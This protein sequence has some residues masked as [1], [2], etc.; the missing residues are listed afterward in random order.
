MKIEDRYLNG[1]YHELNPDWDRGD[2][3]WK[4]GHVSEMILKHDVLP[5][6]ICEI[7]CGSGD[8]LRNLMLN[9]PNAKM[10]GFDVSPALTN[11]WHED[12][13]CENKIKFILGN[14]D[15]INTNYFDLLLMLDVFEHVRDPFSFL[16]M[17]RKHSKKFIFHIPLDLSAFSVARGQPLIYARR[18]VGHLNFYDKD[19]ALETLTDC[20]YKIIDWKYTGSS[21]NMPNRSYKTKFA[22]Y[23]RSF[24][25]QINRDLS[26]RIM[27]GDTLIV[28]AE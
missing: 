15:E 3:A 16:E 2:S 11:F 26:V 28:F 19:L 4:A 17:A 13:E 27:G 14:I 25:N 20:G 6:S 18:Q 5:E 8:I 7:G 10:Y 9:H 12:K 1:Q 24:F 22:G 23:F 21:L